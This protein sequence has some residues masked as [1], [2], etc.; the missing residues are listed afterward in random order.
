MCL[1]ASVALQLPCQLLTSV[2][3]LSFFP[4]LLLSPGISFLLAHS[5]STLLLLQARQACSTGDLSSPPPVLRLLAGVDSSPLDPLSPLLPAINSP[6]PQQT[7]HEGSEGGSILS[8]PP[9]PLLAALSLSLPAASGAALPTAATA[10]LFL[11]A[12]S[13]GLW[14]CSQKSSG[15]TAR[16]PDA[17][18]SFQVGVSNHLGH[19]PDTHRHRGGLWQLS[20]DRTSVSI[21]CHV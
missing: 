11:H 3:L 2:L 4:P 8:P 7:G 1:V 19:E 10:T 16:N 6:Q 12:V 9:L 18:P 15:W 17:V 5:S 20:S 14:I 21:L 13:W